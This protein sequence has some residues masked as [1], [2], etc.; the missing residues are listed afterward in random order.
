MK[1]EKGQQE[2]SRSKFLQPKWRSR[3]LS[4]AAKPASRDKQGWDTEHTQNVALAR[5]PGVD[6][7]LT[8][9]S[10]I[11]GLS[12]YPRVWRKY[13]MPLKSL[14]FGVGG[15]R[16]QH[17]LW[18]LQNGEME[19]DVKVVVVL[20]GT[21]NI[22]KNSPSEIVQGIL[23]IVDYIRMKK[24]AVSIIVC[25]ILPRDLFPTARRED[26]EEVNDEL[27]EYISYSEE[28]ADKNVIFLAP[29]KGWTTK[30]GQLDE[31]LYFTDHLHLIEEGDEKLAK[32]ISRLVKDLL[33]ADEDKDDSLSQKRLIKVLS[34]SSVIELLLHNEQTHFV[35]PSLFS[36]LLWHL[37]LSCF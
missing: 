12:R 2:G 17:V 32:S 19:C 11:K 9:D 10:I 29:G 27:F 6:V 18:R 36:L 33:K 34:L 20:C 4:S 31:S 24:P 3:L 22:E 23:A 16:T 28:L 7:L 37:C 30:G 1:K 26:I 35:M 21:N 14:N 25:G 8:G 15:D 13:F 5:R